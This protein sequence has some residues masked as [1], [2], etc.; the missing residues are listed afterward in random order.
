MKQLCLVAT[1]LVLSCNGSQKAISENTALAPV[2]PD[3]TNLAASIS[4]EELREH[5]FT[6]ASDDF[7]GRETG[8][9]GQKKAVAYIQKA[10]EDLGIQGALKDGAYFQKVPLEM[11]RLPKGSMAIG[12]QVLENGQGFLTFTGL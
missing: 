11:A 8:K 10:Y 1:A 7:E 9:E 12:D 3:V 5:L 6:Y 2:K 4:E